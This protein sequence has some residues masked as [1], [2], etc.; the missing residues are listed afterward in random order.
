MHGVVR[1]F[2]T[3]HGVL[4]AVDV[5]GLPTMYKTCENSV[6]GFHIHGGNQCTGDIN[7]VFSNAM[8]HYTS[9]NCNH[10]EHS[11]DLPPLFA[12]HGFAFSVFLTNR[13]SLRDVIGKTMII[14]EKPDD[15]ITQ[16]SGNAGKKI[17]CGVIKSRKEIVK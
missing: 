5:N 2:Q 17:A 14:H 16:P 8:S 7:D 13:F 1:F 10:P 9:V 15:F 12:N 3:V 4:V 6:F 11:G